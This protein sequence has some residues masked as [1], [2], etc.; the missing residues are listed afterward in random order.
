VNH[1][2]LLGLALL[3]S[4]SAVPAYAQTEI[5]VIAAHFSD[6]TVK[7]FEKA[8]ER[9]EAAHPD[10]DVII[11][12]V[13]WD[14]LQQRLATD[15][16]GGTAP[17]ISV[18][19]TRWVLDYVQNDIAEPLDTYMT[20]EFKA[21]FYENLFA[22]G[23]VEGKTYLLPILASTRAL[24]YNQDL[25]AKAGIA[26][27][28]KT[29][30]ELRANAEAIKAKGEGAY[31][32]GVQGK[33]IETDTYWYYPFW[34]MGG[35]IV[36]DGK[37]GINSEAGVKATELYKSMIDAGL[38]QP[39]PTGSNRQDIE[40]LFKQGRVG[41][42]ISGPWL[43][44]QI[45]EE[46]PD[47]KYGISAVPM[48]TTQATW[49]GSDSVMLFKS[50]KNKELAWKFIEEGLFA[51]ETRLEFTLTEGFLPVLK[52]EMQD[53]RLADDASLKS[54][55]DMLPYAKFAPLLPRWEEIVAATISAIQ[56]A[57]LGQAEPKAALDA[58]AA[59]IDGL[60]AGQ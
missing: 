23:V 60:L 37:S 34:T 22:P 52:E 32:F 54:F 57:Y 27:P 15:V 43:R 40:T 51:T 8:A 44:G 47:L 3:A 19:A 28:P 7:T 46:A 11:E 17:D 39:S 53:P 26:A 10:V 29:W 2:A 12:D 56:Q 55:A 31:G 38:T 48:G 16:A 42:I 5:R 58:A 35:E 18:I 1:F 21:R 13:S 14:N 50:S 45:K 9:F 36:V 20:P 6:N 30:D 41:A 24:Y 33:E 59:Q 4:T 25:F 49:A